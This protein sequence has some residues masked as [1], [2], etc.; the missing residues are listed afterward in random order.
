[1]WYDRLSATGE[2][3]PVQLTSSLSEQYPMLCKISK[4][5]VGSLRH[6]KT[7][8]YRANYRL[9]GGNHDVSIV[10]GIVYIV[11]FST[12]CIVNAYV[13]THLEDG[14]MMM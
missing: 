8:V 14:Q 12:V 1:M 10:H 5:F 4:S 3:K 6:I 7:L 2:L 13:L 9:D 11:Q